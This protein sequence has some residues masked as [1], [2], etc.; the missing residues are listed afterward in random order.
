M[1]LSLMLLATG[2]TI[3]DQS[4]QKLVWAI[5]LYHN[6]GVNTWRS[7]QSGNRSDNMGLQLGDFSAEA[8][9]NW[10]Q[11]RWQRTGKIL[12]EMETLF[13]FLELEKGRELKEMKKT[14]KNSNDNGQIQMGTTPS[15]SS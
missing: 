14:E 4:E 3:I 2:L 9:G 10:M 5:A 6:N 11:F 13:G 7:S 15:I 12:E 1:V 8:P